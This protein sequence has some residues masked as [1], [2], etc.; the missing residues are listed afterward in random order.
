MS[1][2][3]Y[4]IVVNDYAFMDLSEPTA[5][6]FA[7]NDMQGIVLLAQGD[8]SHMPKIDP[9]HGPTIAIDGNNSH[10]HPIV[11]L[12][13]DKAA[14]LRDFITMLRTLEQQMSAREQARQA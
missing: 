10:P 4:S 2:A 8:L 11:G 7:N 9:E 5:T 1:E 6:F 12:A 13:F 14:D 3:E